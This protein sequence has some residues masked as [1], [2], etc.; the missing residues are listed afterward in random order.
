MQRWPYF[1]S[2]TSN[3][4]SILTMKNILILIPLVC[5]LQSTKAQN[6]SLKPAIA[7]KWAPTGLLL[8]SVS[9]QGEYNFG[10]NSLTAKI[11]VPANTH[12]NFTYEDNDANFS[13]KATSFM[14]GYRIYLSKQQLKGLYLEP[15][16]KY[17]HHTAEGVG[18]GTLSGES[19]ELNFTNNYN[20]FGAGAQLGAQFLIGKKFIID[21]FLLGPEINSSMNNFKAVEVSNS[22]PW[23]FIQ[24]REAE[25][26]IRDFV[27]QFPFVRNRTSVMVDKDNRTVMANF[28]GA[29]PGFRT[30]VSFGFLF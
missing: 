9:L 2:L 19:I 1:Y 26:D 18:T 12:R 20:G 24:A 10:K 15:Y 6:T 27:D 22:L 13:M 29:L 4:L 17:V 25:N 3:L 11:G 14:A 23:T 7:V 28:K 21:L 16:F 8:G 30:G 5:L